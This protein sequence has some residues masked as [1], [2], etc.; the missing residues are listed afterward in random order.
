MVRDHSL[1]CSRWMLLMFSLKTQQ[2]WSPS[3]VPGRSRRAMSQLWVVPVSTCLFCFVFD[4]LVT[5]GVLGQ[6]EGGGCRQVRRWH[7]NQLLHGV[8]GGKLLLPKRRHTATTTQSVLTRKREPG[9]AAT[10]KP[11]VNALN[12]FFSFGKHIYTGAVPFILPCLAWIFRSY[13]A[14]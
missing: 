1:N 7:Q 12:F 3:S 5:G 11:K 2:K 9:P 8:E 4:T 10:A 13:A 14:V 6:Q